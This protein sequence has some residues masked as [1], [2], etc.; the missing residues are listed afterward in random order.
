MIKELQRRVN[1]IREPI[2]SN[3]YIALVSGLD[4]GSKGSFD[5]KTQML[6][7]YLSGELGGPDVSRMDSSLIYNQP[8]NDRIKNNAPIYRD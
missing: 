7:E 1:L 5:I 2:E 4:L 8:W 3:K 6:T